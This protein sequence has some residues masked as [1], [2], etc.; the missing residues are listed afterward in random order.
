MGTEPMTAAESRIS[1]ERRGHVL[2]I[3]LNRAAKRNAFDPAM[4]DE[5]GQAYALLETDDALRCG[6]LWAHGDHF[7]GGL[8]LPTF[9]PLLD[10][11]ENPLHLDDDR[12]DPVNLTGPRRLKP[13]VSAIQGVC[14]TIGIELM[15]ATDIRVAAAS[16]RFGQIEVARGIYPFGGAT[17]RFPREAGWGNAM[18]YLLT[19]AMFDAAEAH[20]IGLVAEVVPH[21]QQV[22]RAIAL[23][24]VVAAQSPLGVRATL[25]SARAALS[26]TEDV[27]AAE[28][29]PHLAPLLSSDD[30]REGVQSFVER[31]TASFTGQ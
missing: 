9:R 29:L 31:R 19:G 5:L 24:E 25:A 17:I 15:L 12:R 2:L 10:A 28:L 27:A 22:E 23:A 20:R 4:Y 16:A 14:L 11:G 6:V 13:I 1:V 3:G 30:A 18:R 21:G 7:T 26:P 8:D